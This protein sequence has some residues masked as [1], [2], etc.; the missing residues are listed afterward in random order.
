MTTGTAF[1][2]E[3]FTGV[4]YGIGALTGVGTAIGEFDTDT[5][6]KLSTTSLLVLVDLT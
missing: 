6:E 4:E 2:T 1:G 3:A 5:T